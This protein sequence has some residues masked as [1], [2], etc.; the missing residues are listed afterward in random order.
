MNKEI[1]YGLKIVVGEPAEKKSKFY[2]LYSNKK[3][4]INDWAQV[5]QESIV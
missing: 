5:I 1:K 2:F 3:Q 4:E